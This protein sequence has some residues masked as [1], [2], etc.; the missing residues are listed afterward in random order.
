MLIPRIYQPNP[1]FVGHSLLL[2]KEASH[3]LIKVLR[4]EA[5]N[6]LILFNG[7]GKEYFATLKKA[8]K[9]CEIVIEE[10]SNKSLESPFPIHLGQSVIRGDRMDFVIQKAVE[11]GVTSLHPL[12]A[13]ASLIK[14]TEKRLEKKEKH[15]QNIIISA[16][17]QCG[18]NS[19]PTLHPVVTFTE[20]LSK[21]L[22]D[23]KLIFH[24]DAQHSLS[25]LNIQPKSIQILI[26]PEAGFTEEE[27]QLS[28]QHNFIPCLLGPR[29]LR[30]E[31]API[32]ALCALQTRFGDF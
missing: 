16:C 21:P 32:A 15:W 20:W 22:A 1:C 2:S 23:C 5:G 19:L 4:L 9:I 24:Q 29:I 8:G 13:T 11:C 12:I 25:T 17:E 30:A 27:V 10:V 14:T 6:N 28:V 31:T 18:R 7:D 3:H 26:G